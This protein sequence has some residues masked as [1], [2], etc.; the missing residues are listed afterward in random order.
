MFYS[1]TE[2][3]SNLYPKNNLTLSKCFSHLF[4]I[5]WFS[6]YI[7]ISWKQADIVSL[8][9]NKIGNLKTNASSYRPISLTSIISRMFE[10]LV[11]NKLLILIEPKISKFQHGFMPKKST[12]D[13]LYLLMSQLQKSFFKK[14]YITCLFC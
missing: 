7:P 6:H 4:N 3:L 13:C 12:S 9:K 11:K 5:I 14:E 10:R 8:F 1:E 2:K